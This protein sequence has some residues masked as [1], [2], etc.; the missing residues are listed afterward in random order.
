MKKTFLVAV[1]LILGMSTSQ[2]QVVQ[3]GFKGGLN[4][5][6]Y[7][8]SDFAGIDFKSITSYHAGLVM[9][10]KVF[11]NLSIQPELLYSTQGSEL[12]GLGDQIKNELGY[13]SLPV[14]AKFYLTSNKLSLELGPQASV[15][16][17][18][19]RKANSSNTNTFDFGLAGGL[20][21]KITEGL[22]ISGRYVAGLTEVKKDADVKNSLVQFSVGFMF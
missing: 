7:T 10:L 18:E 12:K 3:F 1:V 20:S 19:R 15:L 11:E 17:S 8:G 22:F 5:A 9:E 2:A 13:L 16:V 21:Y 6:N 14:L 4:F